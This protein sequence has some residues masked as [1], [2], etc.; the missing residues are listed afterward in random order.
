MQTAVVRGDDGVGK[1]RGNHCIRPHQSAS[2]QPFRA[3]YAAGFF[4]IGEMQFEGAAEFVALCR[5]LQR[6]Q[7]PCVSCEIRFRYSQA[8]A[9]H[10]RTLRPLLDNRPVRIDPPP[11]T[12]RHDVTMGIERN[13]RAIAETMTDD[14]IGR[15]PHAGRLNFGARHLVHLNGK[16]EA[17][18]EFADA[19]GVRRAIAR[20]IIARRLH[21]F[22]QEANLALKIAIDKLSHDARER[23]D[24]SARRSTASSMTRAA[25]SASSAVMI[26]R[27]EWLTPPFPQRTN[28]MATSVSSA[29][30]MASWPAPLGRWRGF[31]PARATASASSF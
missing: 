12:G 31:T 9:V 24:S 3:D 25:I 17:F 26:S 27:G 23:H 1:T 10:G 2:E 18:Q 30:I 4:V 7:S 21:Q 14:E 20:R 13:D 19:F 11:E 16:P 6:E 28:N 22:G 8:A 15:A 29:N 5:R